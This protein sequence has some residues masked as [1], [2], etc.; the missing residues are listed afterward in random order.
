MHK[1]MYV[2]MHLYVSAFVCM[3]VCLYTTIALQPILSYYLA[4]DVRMQEVIPYK[5]EAESYTC[6]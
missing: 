3:C 6:G 4:V 1:C 2:C 5:Y